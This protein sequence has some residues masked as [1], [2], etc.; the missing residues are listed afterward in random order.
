[1]E[2][3]S[4]E[5]DEG[6]LSE[7]QQTKLEQEK[8]RIQQDENMAQEEKKKLLH[9]KERKI[10]DIKK[11]Q[12]AKDALSGKIKAMESK[13]LVG[14]R[15]IV[16]HTNEQER[17]LQAKR[18]EIAEQLTKEREMKQK[19]EEREGS[20]LEAH[21]SYTSLQQEVDVKTKK[22]KKIYTKLQ[23]AKS[24]LA[25]LQNNFSNDRIELQETQFEL[26]REF[27]VRA[28]IIE[29]FIPP[30]ERKKIEERIYF[31]DDDD[32]Y[33]LKSLHDSKLAMMK[34]PLSAVS[35]EKRPKS[36]YARMASS[37]DI[38]NPR[39]RS[40][41]MLMVELDMPTRTTR[42][43]EGPL[44]APKVQAALNAALQEE[45]DLHLDASADIFSLRSKKKSKTR[46]KSAR[47]KSGKT[48]KQEDPSAYPRSRGLVP[49]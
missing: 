48:S 44:V 5:T 45:S 2:S 35:G 43:Y 39:F 28:L 19:L 42:D 47:S 3:E 25:D 36:M 16:D 13:L 46:T 32:C 15:T 12:Q 7:D 14:G 49:K 31:D 10:H 4:D 29:N 34:R 11:Q 20:A 18:R 41:N 1:M 38:S 9:E 21:E 22:L 8:L 33:K 6:S 37:I 30:D 23:L 24:E 27:K 26:S 40:E 17:A